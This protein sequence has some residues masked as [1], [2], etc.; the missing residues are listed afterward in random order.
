M[1]KY[2]Q[3]Q[4]EQKYVLKRKKRTRKQKA[5][6]AI[7]SGVGS[8]VSSAVLTSLF[9]AGNPK[10]LKHGARF[11]AM[12]APVI[13]TLSYLR[14]PN[15]GV[16]LKKVAGV[17]KHFMRGLRRSDVSQMIKKIKDKKNIGKAV[18]KNAIVKDLK[19]TKGTKAKIT[20][21][22]SKVKGT[23]RKIDKKV[24]DEFYNSKIVSEKSQAAYNIGRHADKIVAG[25]AGAAG[26]GSYTKKRLNKRKKSKG[27]K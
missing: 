26:A 10:A 3:K 15:Y 21:F 1:G 18:D 9:N 22:I 13:G 25:A 17:K 16:Q 24:V 23:G 12:V 14:Q 20:K 8:G 19:L 11:G 6:R 5:K 4:A 7:R 2:L 27:G